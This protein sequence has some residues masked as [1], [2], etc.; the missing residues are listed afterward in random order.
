MIH[1]DDQIRIFHAADRSDCFFCGTDRIFE[2][3][4][5]QIAAWFGQRCVGAGNAEEYD[6]IL[7]YF[8]DCVRRSKRFSMEHQVAGNA[9]CTD[10]LHVH[11]QG[12][13]TAGEVVIAEIDIVI[14]HFP[15]DR[16]YRHDVIRMT[17]HVIGSQWCADKGISVV[18]KQ[19]TVVAEIGDQCMDA[20]KSCIVHGTGQFIERKDHSVDIRCHKNS[21]TFSHMVL[22]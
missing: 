5:A 22:P 13:R 3:E 4:A 14:F 6:L 11:H 21:N 8:A 9:R 18:H 19:C 20:G 10:V 2:L 17:A 7:P 12:F 15:H 16:R 1:T